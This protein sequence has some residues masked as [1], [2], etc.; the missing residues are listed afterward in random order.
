MHVYCLY[1]AHNKIMYGYLF[2]TRDVDF[3]TKWGFQG[4]VADVFARQAWI[5]YVALFLPLYHDWHPL[6]I[7]SGVVKICGTWRWLTGYSLLQVATV[8]SFYSLHPWKYIFYCSSR[9]VFFKYVKIKSI[10]WVEQIS[11]QFCWRVPFSFLFERPQK[12]IEAK[13]SKICRNI[14]HSL[15]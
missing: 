7:F 5:C 2:C 12:C 3:K 14:L 9:N 10:Y 15:T 8:S 4:P 11:L 13:N 1:C 6:L